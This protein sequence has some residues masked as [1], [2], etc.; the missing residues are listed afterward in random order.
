M[1]KLDQHN[2]VD[3]S[4]SSDGSIFDNASPI[5]DKDQGVQGAVFKCMW[6]NIPAI[7]KM[8]NHIDFVL[9]LEEEAWNRLKNLNCLHFCEVLD[10]LPIKPGER[11]YCLFYKEIINNFQNDSL[12][13]LI[14]EQD[15]HPNAIL[16]CVR[17]TLA[18]IIMFEKLGIT[19]YDLHSDNT[20][21]TDTPYDVHVY[22]FGNDIVPIRTYGIAPVIIDFG[23]AYIPASRYNATCAFSKD[24]FTTFMPDPIVDSRLLLMTTIIELKGLLKKIRIRK[25]FSSHYRDTY[26]I[27]ERFIK[28]VELIFSPLKV[29]ENGWY[30]KEDIFPNIVDELME[31]LP[32]SL[33]KTNRGIFKNDNFD[34]IIELLQHEI[35][36]PITYKPDVPS[37]NK[38]TCL[39]AI[40]WKTVEQIIRNTREEQLFFKDLVSI[41]RGANT[42]TYTIMR[43]RYPKIKNIKRLKNAVENMGDAFSNFLF[44]KERQIGNIKESMY[45]KLPFRSTKD[46]LRALP[47]I[48]NKYNG[49]MTMIIM[50]PTSPDH[51]EVVIDEEMANL[52]N[53]NEQDVLRK[54]II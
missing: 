21:V 44:E 7:M 40:E 52:L 24:G 34:W 32:K 37:F 22:K 35:F 9:E 17:Q 8:S 19:H 10:K 50:D 13:N 38:A 31:Q 18:A 3:D 29:Q 47:S 2:H 45:N 6:K 48:P 1:N 20:M 42:N 51:K 30:K 23:L 12:A 11:R 41:P 46:I 5:D 14:Y 26:V 25:A 33:Q 15:H 54:Y 27:I 4:G 36:I 16:N 28:K 39:L 49:G 43:C 53:E